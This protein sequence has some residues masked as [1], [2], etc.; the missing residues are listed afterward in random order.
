VEEDERRSLAR[1]GDVGAEAAGVDEPVL[2]VGDLGEGSFHER[3]LCGVPV[4]GGGRGA[5][6]AR[7]TRHG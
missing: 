3:E 2:D 5:A 7:S 1:L 6:A 4:A